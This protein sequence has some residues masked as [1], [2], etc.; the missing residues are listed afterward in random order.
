MEWTHTQEKKREEIATVAIN[1]RMDRCTHYVCYVYVCL[2]RYLV[3]TDRIHS[4]YVR[5][6][7]QEGAEAAGQNLHPAHTMACST[8]NTTHNPTHGMCQSGV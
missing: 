3:C 1:Q 2:Y 7:E 5:K 4:P 6:E 8:H